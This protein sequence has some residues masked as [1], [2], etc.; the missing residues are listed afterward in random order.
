MSNQKK[1]GFSVRQENV[2]FGLQRQ[3]TAA[4]P[5]PKSIMEKYSNAMTPN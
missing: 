4:M 2:N 5:H 3:G 1:V